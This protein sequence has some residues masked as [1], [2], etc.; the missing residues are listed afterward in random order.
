MV[1]KGRYHEAKKSLA[2]LTTPTP[3]IPFDL[4]GAVSMIKSTDELEKAM[5]EGTNYIDCFRGVD[6]RRTEIA[7]MAWIAQAFC[8][9]AL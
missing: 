8:G 4:D 5:G 2:A 3:E 1:R 9:A 7:S 6:L